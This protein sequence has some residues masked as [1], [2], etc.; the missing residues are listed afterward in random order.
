MREHRLYTCCCLVTPTQSAY[1]PT[2]FNPVLKPY[3]DL[4]ILYNWEGS[5]N[6]Q[7]QSGTLGLSGTDWGL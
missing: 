6:L 1:Y 7:A 3:L 4:L 5:S 2:S